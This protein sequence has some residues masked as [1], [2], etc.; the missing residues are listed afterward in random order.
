[1][2]AEWG[3]TRSLPNGYGLGYKTQKCQTK[4]CGGCEKGWHTSADRRIIAHF[5]GDLVWFIH[6]CFEDT[7]GLE[8][9]H[10]LPWS[11]ELEDVVNEILISEEC[12][13][14]SLKAISGRLWK[15]WL[16][17]LK[18]NFAKWFQIEKIKFMKVKSIT[19]KMQKK[20][21]KSEKIR[22]EAV[23]GNIEVNVYKN[24][25][26]DIT[27]NPSDPEICL[28][29]EKV[30]ATGYFMSKETY[31]ITEEQYNDETFWN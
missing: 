8:D 6:Y 30:Y 24:V 28:S 15:E 2:S 10:N 26:F 18:S 11:K 5:P 7:M 12:Q 20:F 23:G 13:K 14:N 22:K 19:F 25:L 1:M 16:I 4:D 9:P 31:H 27:P 17:A 29:V 3:W 21:M